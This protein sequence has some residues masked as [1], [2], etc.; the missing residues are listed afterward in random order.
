MHF[1][2]RADLRPPY[3]TIGSYNFGYIW[4]LLTIYASI[5]IGIDRLTTIIGAS[6]QSE[7]RL[8]TRCAPM[9]DPDSEIRPGDVP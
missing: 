5:A 3:V 6:G 4:I 7:I 9:I 8:T 2:A 1:F